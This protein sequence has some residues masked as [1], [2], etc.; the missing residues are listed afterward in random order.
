MLASY[1]KGNLPPKGEV[2]RWGVKTGI[3]PYCA[4]IDPSCTDPA[5]QAK[6]PFVHDSVCKY[7]AFGAWVTAHVQFENS[8]WL[9]NVPVGM[10]SL[11]MPSTSTADATLPGLASATERDMRARSQM[12]ARSF[13]KDGLDY[14]LV[15]SITQLFYLVPLTLHFN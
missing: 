14:W 5:V 7:Y 6:L 1:L 4:T 3:A 8:I 15:S 13:C 11:A 9:V 12:S 10:F 2:L